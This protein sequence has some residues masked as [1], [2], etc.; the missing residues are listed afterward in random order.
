MGA[1]I[2][3]DFVSRLK[4]AVSFAWALR[5]KYASICLNLC[6]DRHES[7]LIGSLLIG[8]LLSLSVSRIGQSV[9]HFFVQE[10][11]L[12]FG[13]S[14]RCWLLIA[15]TLFSDVDESSVWTE[16]AKCSCTVIPSMLAY[17]PAGLPTYIPNHLGNLILNI[18]YRPF[19]FETLIVKLSSRNS[20][21]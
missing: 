14:P 6:T 20:H 7:N 17:L 16:H 8:S 12:S 21:F 9:D 5:D 11:R 4:L 15:F 1:A 2:V 10:S 3:M 13:W 19:H 18:S